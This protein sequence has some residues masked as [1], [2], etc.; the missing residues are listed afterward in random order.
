MKYVFDPERI[1]NWICE[2]AGGHYTYLC[3]AIG[4]EDDNGELK[5]AVMYENYTGGNI[6]MVWR[7]DDPKY[8]TRKF[9]W[10]AFDYPFNQLGCFRVSGVVRKDNIKAIKVDEKLGFTH[11]HTLRQFNND[12]TDAYL[13]VMF[14]QDCRFIRGRYANT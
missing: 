11:E 14:K 9:Y 2:K 6:C 1:C 13:Y 5:A 10:M 7:C 3:T 12:G 4:V 8:A